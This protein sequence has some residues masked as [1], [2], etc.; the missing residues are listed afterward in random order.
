MRVVRR[1]LLRSVIDH[2][3][4]A[5]GPPTGG[6]HDTIGRGYRD[7]VI[8]HHVPLRSVRRAIR[9]RIALLALEHDVRAAV[10]TMLARRAPA[11]RDDRLAVVPHRNRPH[12][13]TMKPRRRG[14]LRRCRWLRQRRR[15][16]L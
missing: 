14:W 2:D 8:R 12:P 9:K 16:W 13:S 3:R 10:W 15:H 5:A 11:R 4:E 6:P 7:D 1:D